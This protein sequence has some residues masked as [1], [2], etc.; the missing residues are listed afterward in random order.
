MK[1]GIYYG[2]TTGTT[3]DVANRIAQ[4]FDDADVNEVSNG[5][6]DFLSYDLL[7]L[8]RPTWGLGDLQ[9]E[10]MACIDEI[11][12]MDLSDKYVA[13]FGTGDQ[14]AFADTFL[15]MLLIY[16]IEKLKVQKQK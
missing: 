3:E 11:D 16:F 12:D 6:D 1:V 4:H 10:W 13:L 7:I 9:D 5:I 2:T 14:E 15:L 8:V